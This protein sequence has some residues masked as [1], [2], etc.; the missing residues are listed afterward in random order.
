[1]SSGF[2]K[3]VVWLMALVIIGS[4]SAFGQSSGGRLTGKVAGSDGKPVA[5]VTVNVTNQTSSD[6]RQT[7]T[8]GDGSYSIKLG[9]GAYRISVGAP[10]EA[11]FDRG[12][13]AEYGTF[14]NIICSAP[15]VCPTLE[16][17]IID[18]SER[19]IDIVVADPSKAVA[20][21]GKPVVTAQP[22]TREVRDRWRAESVDAHLGIPSEAQSQWL[23]GSNGARR[24]VGAA[25][26]I[27]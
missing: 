9:N 26:R 19:K 6:S 8:R 23:R 13:A 17:V 5:G 20:A 7:R 2:P 12:K 22:D 16:N 3:L 27:G 14:A 21:D 25:L 4:T 10:Y 24:R 1:M 18:G 15:Q 11:R